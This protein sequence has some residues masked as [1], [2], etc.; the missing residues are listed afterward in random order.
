MLINLLLIISWIVTRIS[1][2]LKKRVISKFFG[3]DKIR[4]Y[5]PGRDLGRKIPV[6]AAEDFYAAYHLAEFLKKHNIIVEL[7]HIP[8][9][10][11]INFEPGSIVICGPKTS[12]KLKEILDSDPC[13]KFKEENGIWK[14][15]ETATNNELISPSDKDPVENI[16]IAYFGRLKL[17]TNDPNFVTVIAGIHAI[18]S[19]GVVRY[20]A[21]L[22]ILKQIDE[23]TNNQRF[24]T[25]IS[26]YYDPDTLEIISSGLQMPIKTH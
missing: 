14:F 15:I 1:E 12:T 26:T 5:F 9:N 11:K 4:I 22:K 2:Y 25:L 8:P 21:N 13:Y 19:Y 7:Q 20:I 17:S 24:S 18:G 6:I 23:A 10:S 3:S 16:D